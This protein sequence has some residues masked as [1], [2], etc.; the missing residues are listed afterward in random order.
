MSRPPEPVAQAIHQRARQ[1]SSRRC[2]PVRASGTTCGISRMVE[3]GRVIAVSLVLRL[4]AALSYT[5]ISMT[6]RRNLV[7][8]RIVCTASFVSSKMAR[9]QVFAKVL[10]LTLSKVDSMSEGV[11]SHC[12]RSASKEERPKV[13]TRQPARLTLH[14]SVRQVISDQRP[15]ARHIYGGVEWQERLLEEK[16]RRPRQYI[17]VG[18]SRERAVV[19]SRN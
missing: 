4:L 17:D 6:S 5:M 1:W 12:T 11:R 18:S 2:T 13:Q 8:S 19:A 9:A 15:F 7:S 10:S 3:R 14:C 16:C